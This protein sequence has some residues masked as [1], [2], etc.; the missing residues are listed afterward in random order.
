MR[1]FEFSGLA[2]LHSWHSFAPGQGR[3]R[4]FRSSRKSWALLEAE[5][6]WRAEPGRGDSRLAAAAGSGCGATER[7]RGPQKE[8]RH[9][10]R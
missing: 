10:G 7:K 1:S 2:N 8:N 9:S 6:V 3:G 5:R 4:A